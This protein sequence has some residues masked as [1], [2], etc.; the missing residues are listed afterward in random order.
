MQKK[1]IPTKSGLL[2]AIEGIDGSGKSTFA[3]GL[4]ECLRNFLDSDNL[5]KKQKITLTKEPAIIL[6]KEPGGTELGKQLRK[7]LQQQTTPL[8]PKAEFLLF[9]A[10]RAQ[11][12]KDI[13]I[14]ALKKNNIV[15]SDRMHISS[16]VYQGYGRGLD[17]NLLKT[18]N[19]WAM[20]GY[21]PDIL[22]YLKI[23]LDTAKQRIMTRN[24]ELTRFEKEKESF[25]QALITGFDN[26]LIHNSGIN[27]SC[28]IVLDGTLDQ[29][30]L[31]TQAIEKIMPILL[32]K[33]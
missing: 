8:D 30:T 28:Y 27:N 9:A 19:N 7:I 14:P 33:K 23:D 17:L 11:H 15:I 16:L 12:F 31:I 4:T 32:N 13:V 6:T 22:F 3:S 20:N 1:T 2:I 25:M 21:A 5:A 26:L 29:H 10:D 18:V 24:K